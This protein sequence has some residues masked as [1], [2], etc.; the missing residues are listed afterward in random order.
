MTEH[1]VEIDITRKRGDTHV[2]AFTLQDSAGAAID[3]SGFSFLMTVDPAEEPPDANNNLF[4]LT[5]VLDDAPNGRFSF[6]PSA[7]EADQ[8]PG[9]YFYDI[10]MIDAGAAIRSIV[11]GKFIF[12]QDITK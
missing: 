5:G 3:I 7:L 12:E 6:A 10:Q 8:A 1:I 9:E 4:Q 2:M 11:E